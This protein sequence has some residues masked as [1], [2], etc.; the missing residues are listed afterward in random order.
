MACRIL[1]PARVGVEFAEQ[2]MGGEQ[3]ERLARLGGVGEGALGVVAGLSM[4]PA[5]R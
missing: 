2:A 4:S 1:V 3:G 5:C